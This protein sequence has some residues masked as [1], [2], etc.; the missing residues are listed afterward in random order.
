MNI[1]EHPI[2]SNKSMELM[3]TRLACTTGN[4]IQLLMRCEVKLNHLE[5]RSMYERAQVI[6]VQ[7]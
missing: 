6:D 4:L 7:I 2:K 3:R 5:R 1:N